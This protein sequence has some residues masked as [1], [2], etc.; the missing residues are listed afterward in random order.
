MTWSWGQGGLT[1]VAPP[2]YT[3]NVSDT[4]S[5]QEDLRSLECFH[6]VYF[7]TS[8]GGLGVEYDNA[9]AEFAA[10]FAPSEVRIL[11]DRPSRCRLSVELRITEEALAA[12]AVRLGYTLGIVRVTRHPVEGRAPGGTPQMRGR[13]PTGW[14]REGNSELL[15]EPVFV[16]SEAQR[17]AES[18]HV[19]AFPQTR[20][21]RVLAASRGH[22]VNRRL[23]PLDA[24]F[25]ANICGLPDGAR[26]LDPFAGLCV[27]ADALA[28]R[29][30]RTTVADADPGLRIGLEQH[31]PGSAVIADARA[32]P[33]AHGAFDGI[34]TEPPYHPADQPAVVDSMAELS[35][36]VVPGGRLALFIADFMLPDLEFVWSTLGLRE[37]SRYPVRRHGI[38]SVCVVLS[39]GEG[40]PP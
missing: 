33:Y 27:L 16:A 6:Q 19:F 28:R 2:R 3:Q 5:A 32:L 26:V 1:R 37:W 31:H 20:N 8:K 40:A 14:L 39:N 34:V 15:F 38:H 17:M 11:R 7:R 29:G 4:G 35:R 36:V 10:V 30:L 9:R 13:W 21:G 22:R 23:S 25:V 12:R 18:P 24:R